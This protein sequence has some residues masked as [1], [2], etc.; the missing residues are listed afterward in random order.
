MPNL[1]NRSKYEITPEK[2]ATFIP[3]LISSGI[4]ILL[5]IYFVIPKYFKSAEVNSELIGLIK[6]KNELNDLKLQYEI[7]NRIEIPED[8]KSGINLAAFSGVIKFLFF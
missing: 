3:V 1:K 5:L 8:I 4:S 6:K 2:A 7:I